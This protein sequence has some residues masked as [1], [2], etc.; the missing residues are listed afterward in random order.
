MRGAGGHPDCAEEL[1]RTQPELDM[2]VDRKCLDG[3]D[4]PAAVY[5][6]HGHGLVRTF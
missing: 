1:V 2:A 5:L 4:E 3:F 6:L